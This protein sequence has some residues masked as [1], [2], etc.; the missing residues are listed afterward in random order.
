MTII[1]WEYF[2]ILAICLGGQI[3][4]MFHNDDRW[5][6]W[7]ILAN[8]ITCLVDL[9]TFIYYLFKG[10]PSQAAWGIG[11]ATVSAFV[12]WW[13]WR[14]WK[15]KKK[16]KEALGAKSRALRDKLVRKVRETQQPRPVK[17]P[18]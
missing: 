1:G 9:G 13:L 3:W 11:G 18:V 16:V 5:R 8:S 7:A 12:V 14:N 2:G 4:S 6:V 17:V 10:N 15:D